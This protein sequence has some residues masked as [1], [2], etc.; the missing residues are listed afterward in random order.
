MKKLLFLMGV[1]I[2]FF[3]SCIPNPE[4]NPDPFIP[5]TAALL[6]KT[7]DTYD[8]GDVITSLYNYN[9][10]KIVSIIT[11]FDEE[12]LF[13]TYSGDLITKLEFKDVDGV[14]TEFNNY[15]YDD[16]HRLV[17]FKRIDPTNDLGDKE[18]YV[19]NTDGTITVTY[20]SGDATTQNLV[21]GTGTISFANGEVSNITS[22]SGTYSYTYDNKSNPLKNVTGWSKIAFTDGEADAVLHNITSQIREDGG[23]SPV[24]FTYTYTYSNDFPVT[25]RTDDNDGNYNTAYFY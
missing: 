3:T 14:V 9:G 22:D 1:S 18:T 25:G 4:E 12:N 2:L 15:E 8:N 21:S 11:D 20:F 24:T 5:P 17:T 19:Y 7:V 13:F 23:S 6:R 10:N 16:T